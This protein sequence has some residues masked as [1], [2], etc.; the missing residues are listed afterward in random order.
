MQHSTAN[1][2]GRVPVLIGLKINHMD[3]RHCIPYWYAVAS[4]TVAAVA[5]LPQKCRLAPATTVRPRTY[6]K[7]KQNQALMRGELDGMGA[8][9]YDSVRV[10]VP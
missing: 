4:R 10:R 7:T 6:L 3:Y 5:S 8:V 2:L 9:P 1:V